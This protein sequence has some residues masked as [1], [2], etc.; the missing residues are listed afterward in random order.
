MSDK[1]YLEWPVFDETHHE[2]AATLEGWTAENLRDTNRGGDVDSSQSC[3][4]RNREAKPGPSRI[5]AGPG[6]RGIFGHGGKHPR[7]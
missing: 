3:A 2:L 1:W 5:Y 7:A 6:R 4:S